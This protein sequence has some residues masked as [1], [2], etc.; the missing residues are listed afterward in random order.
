MANVCRLSLLYRSTPD[1][2]RKSYQNLVDATPLD[3]IQTNL[4][5]EIGNGFPLSDKTGGLNGV[6]AGVANPGE[7]EGVRDESPTC[8]WRWKPTGRAI[9]KAVVWTIRLLFAG[10]P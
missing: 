4:L 8:I 3:A 2:S 9:I 1:A 6:L 10:T 5:P 7:S